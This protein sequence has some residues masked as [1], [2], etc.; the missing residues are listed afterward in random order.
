MNYRAK[1]FHHDVRT[2]SNIPSNVLCNCSEAHLS[3]NP[4]NA[5]MKLHIIIMNFGLL[6]YSG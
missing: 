6:T 4:T 5:L 3:E 1:T 2:L